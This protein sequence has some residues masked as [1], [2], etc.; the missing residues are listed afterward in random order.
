MVVTKG[1][2]PLMRS[3]QAE[4]LEVGQVCPGLPDLADL[5]G[6][7]LPLLLDLL[8]QLLLQPPQ[9]LA[10]CLHLRSNILRTT[11]DN[12]RETRFLKISKLL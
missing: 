2:R 3:Y 1:T 12:S 8:L 7:Q 11:C 5:L 6:Q 4:A 9:P 10:P